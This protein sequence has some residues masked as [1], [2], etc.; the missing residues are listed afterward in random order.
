MTPRVES[1]SSELVSINH[2]L[3]PPDISQLFSVAG[4]DLQSTPLNRGSVIR[5]KYL[6]E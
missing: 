2:N 1:K 5:F 3:A 4:V 6:R